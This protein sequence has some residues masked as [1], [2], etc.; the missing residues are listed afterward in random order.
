MIH[1]DRGIP[2]GWALGTESTCRTDKL[3]TETGT[4]TTERDCTSLCSN[5]LAILLER[6]W[7]THYD[8]KL[9]KNWA[10]HRI[11]PFFECHQSMQCYSPS[12]RASVF[13]SLLHLRSD[14]SGKQTH[15]LVFFFPFCAHF[16]LLLTLSLVSR[17][18]NNP[19]TTILPLY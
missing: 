4:C 10:K 17:S 15:A 8:Q 6:L 9:L 13:Q 2:V 11:W 1:R 5:D 14:P 19:N 18:D 3:N 16:S 12:T 7:M